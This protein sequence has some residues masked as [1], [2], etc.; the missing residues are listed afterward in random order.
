MCTRALCSIHLHS[1]NTHIT[2]HYFERSLQDVSGERGYTMWGC[3]CCSSLNTSS[4][5][6][7]TADHVTDWWLYHSAV[8]Q[9]TMVEACMRVRVCLCESNWRASGPVAH[10]AW[11]S[12]CHQDSSEAV[13]RGFVCASLTG[14]DQLHSCCCFFCL[15]LLLL[16]HRLLF[17]EMPKR[18]RKVRQTIWGIDWLKEQ[19]ALQE[20]GNQ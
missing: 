6:D 7:D 16:C 12:R 11:S 9:C 4:I 19:D 1:R 14:K 8:W 18:G 10:S 2:T 15:S 17:K 20:S 3:T 5:H 13:V